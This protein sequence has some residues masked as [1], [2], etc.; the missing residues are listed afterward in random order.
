VE[1]ADW[2]WL[3]I[4]WHNGNGVPNVLTQIELTRLADFMFEVVEC[5]ADYEEDEFCC[6]FEGTRLYVER[7]LSHYRIEIGHENN[8]V[9]LPRH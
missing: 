3:L 5:D 4:E 7:Y 8:V 9:E 1:D 2:F 6:T